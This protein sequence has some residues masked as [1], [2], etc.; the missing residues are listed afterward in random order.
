MLTEITYWSSQVIMSRCRVFR[1]TYILS[2]KKDGQKMVTNGITLDEAPL[3][4]LAQGF[5]PAK[6]ETVD[7]ND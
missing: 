2:S 6:I 7:E 4:E 1:T 5:A 3:G